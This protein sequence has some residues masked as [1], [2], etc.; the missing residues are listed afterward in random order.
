M[1]QT[2]PTLEDKAKSFSYVLNAGNIK[3]FASPGIPFLTFAHFV[4]I[5]Q[6]Y[7]DVHF[8]PDH[9]RGFETD[10]GTRYQVWTRTANSKY[11]RHLF[12]DEIRSPVVLQFEVP[13]PT[14]S[15]WFFLLVKMFDEQGVYFEHRQELVIE[16]KVGE[17]MVLASWKRVPEIRDFLMSDRKG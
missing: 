9:V 11:H 1:C 8:A 14:H 7:R 6:W 10:I 5:V 12:P 16:M 13:E 17:R 4:D 2:T 3:T 15:A